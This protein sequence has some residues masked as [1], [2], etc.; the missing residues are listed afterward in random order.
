MARRRDPEER[1]SDAERERVVGALGAHMVSGRLDSDELSARVDAVLA[2]QTRLDLETA[3]RGLPAVPERPLLVRAADLVPLRI[4]LIAYVLASAI[5]VG[6]W[7]VTRERDPG[8]SDEG[9]GLLWPFWIMLVWGVLVIA[10][11][12]YTLRRPLLATGAR[13]RRLSE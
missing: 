8:R 7:A 3:M 9:F 2:A 11:A 12:L 13:E 10:Q 1:V 4:H 5:L 6:I